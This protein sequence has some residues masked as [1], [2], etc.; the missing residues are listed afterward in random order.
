MMNLFGEALSVS[1]TKNE[2]EVKGEALRW[3]YLGMTFQIIVMLVALV[4]FLVWVVDYFVHLPKDGNIYVTPPLNEEKVFQLT[5]LL[6]KNPNMHKAQQDLSRLA[7]IDS[8]QIAKRADGSWFVTVEESVPIAKSPADGYLFADGSMLTENLPIDFLPIFIGASHYIPQFAPVMS[9]LSKQLQV[10][11]VIV[12][13]FIIDDGGGLNVELKG[14]IVLYMGSAD[15]DARAKRLMLFIAN[16]ENQL[17]RIKSIDL[18]YD[19]ALSIGWRE[20]S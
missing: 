17:A 19:D 18:R 15:Y 5:E 7:W 12:E 13:K 10:H 2:L 3:S 14:D 6:R 9:L 11:E 1:S 16:Y 8:V 20:K 4:F